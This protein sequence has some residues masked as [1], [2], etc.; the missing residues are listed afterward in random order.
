MQSRHFVSDVSYNILN[1][2]DLKSYKRIG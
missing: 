1:L 2:K